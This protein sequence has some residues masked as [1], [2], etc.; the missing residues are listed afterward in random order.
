MLYLFSFCL[1]RGK[2]LDLNINFTGSISESHELLDGFDGNHCPV[3]LNNA[4][5]GDVPA[6]TDPYKHRSYTLNQ[7]D[8]V[9]CLH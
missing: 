8:H 2:E 9:F 1:S 4:E 3:P 6:A 7:N 5:G